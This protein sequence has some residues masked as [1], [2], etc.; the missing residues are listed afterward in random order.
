MVFKCQLND[1]II[2]P[3]FGTIF[4]GLWTVSVGQTIQNLNE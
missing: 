4:Y 3:D 1:W 2:L